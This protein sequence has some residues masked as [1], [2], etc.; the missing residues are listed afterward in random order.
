MALSVRKN[1]DAKLQKISELKLQIEHLKSELQSYAVS[2]HQLSSE[3]AR[4]GVKRIAASL[5][6]P[7]TSGDFIVAAELHSG[8]AVSRR[9]CFEGFE[10]EAAA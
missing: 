10:R 1:C 8:C 7:L 3:T 2:L 9:E 4:G 5:S 6:I